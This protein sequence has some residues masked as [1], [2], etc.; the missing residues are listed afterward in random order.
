M[1]KSRNV[2]SITVFFAVALVLWSLLTLLPGPRAEQLPND[3]QGYYDLFDYDF[4]NTVYAVAPVWESW[5]NELYKPQELTHIKPPVSQQTLD[6]ESMQA[7]T[8]RMRFDL[9]AD[10]AYGITIESA[11]YAMRIFVNG[12]EV[13][14]VGIPG[15]TREQTVP[16]EGSFTCSF[17]SLGETTEIVLQVSN[18]VH[19]AGAYAPTLI[20]GS[21]ENIAH[22][23]KLA[24][25]KSGMIFGCLF[26][27]GLYHLAIFLLN[28]NQIAVL[29]FAIPCLLQAFVSVNFLNQLF[30]YLDWQIAVRLEYVFFIAA[31]M[32][33]VVLIRKLFPEAL[34]RVISGVYLAICSTF[35]FIVLITDTVFFTRLLFV[36]QGASFVMAAYV[37][38]RLAMRLFQ[39]QTTKNVLAFT[40]IIVVALFSVNE[41][42]MRNGLYL[43]GNISGR[44]IGVSEGMVFFVLCYA[45]LLSIEQAEVNEKLKELEKALANAEAHYEN[46]LGKH[47]SG[48][49]S[50]Q[51][52]DFGLTKRE[53]EVALLLL[54][55]MIRE[56]IAR[57]LS[58]S[59]G[60][61]NFHCTNIY[62][63]T[64]VSGLAELTRSVSTNN[65]LKE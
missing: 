26:I 19:R 29:L 49:P 64:S 51:L 39:E 25:L 46:L 10:N 12:I 37:L 32:F 6:H 5:P 34:N 33:L 36:F 9:P 18:F 54:D 31:V 28:R 59:M 24:N 53:T 14:N 11:D 30:P 42:L 2:V 8:Y 13:G 55:G 63:K 65:L 35:I 17:T 41:A 4:T 47:Q 3:T 44:L 20:I 38:V 62:R 50:V 57:L 23:D 1:S 45:L 48:R 7:V 27:A 22:A 52:S 56:D 15:E 43:F 16:Q 61:V 40:G 21:A 60:T 58:I